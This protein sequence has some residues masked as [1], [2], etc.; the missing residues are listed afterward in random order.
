MLDVALRDGIPH[1]VAWSTSR[2]EYLSAHPDEGRIFDAFMARMPDDRH[3]AV[4]TSYDFSAAAKII[5]LGGGNGE[6]LRRVLARF[7][8]PRGLV[9]DRE[10]VVAAIP[11]EARLNGRIDVEHGSF[12]TRVPSGA[13][14]YLLIRVLHDWSDEDCVRILGN[15]RAAMSSSSRLLIVEQMLNPDPARGHPLAYLLDVQMMAMFGSAR[16]RTQAEFEELL[17][18]SGLSLVTL[19]PTAS[20]VSILEVAPQ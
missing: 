18:A 16:E 1:E 15:C 13:D 17:A 11:A 14:M 4:A 12:L 10:D 19:I 5:D 9:F 8:K 7:P 2:F 20:A 6:T 3:D